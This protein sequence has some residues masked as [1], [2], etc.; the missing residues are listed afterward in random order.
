M[1]S[2]LLAPVGNFIALQAAIE[3]GADEIFFGVQGFNMRANA[4]NFKQSD[5]K[6]VIKICH[7]NDVKAY[8]AINIIIYENELTKLKKVL[9]K[10]KEAEID[11]II[12]WDM[13]VVSEAEKLKIPIHLSTQASVSNYESL[14]YYKN[15]IKL[16]ERVVLA[17]ECTLDQIK[18][19]IKKIKRDK[20]G[21]EIETFIH[22]AMCVSV[23][24]RCFMSQDMFGKSANRGE[25]IQ[26]C[27]REYDTIKIKDPEENKELYLG[28][29]YVMSPKDMCT[30]KIIDL[31]ID[32]GITSFK[33]E[34]RNRN[35]EYVANVI[36][37][38]RTIMDYYNEY[39]L[40]IKQ[41]PDDKKEYEKLKKQL[42]LKLDNSYNRGFSDGFYMGKPINQ[43][44]GVYGSKSKEHKQ[45]VG[46]ITNYFKKI[47]VAEI[48]VT[49][50]SIKK[51]DE[52]YIQGPTTGVIKQKVS[53][54][55]T[56]GIDNNNNKCNIIIKEATK[57]K[58]ISIKVEKLVRKNDEL[59]KII[60]KTK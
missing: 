11:A 2:K 32:A 25:C 18:S 34:G 49:S 50:Y 39:K 38:Y 44:S 45:Y 12:A 15:K 43:W 36:D 23:S 16:L 8:L 6:K 13:A 21:V 51:N 1:Y 58:L 59:Y 35:P 3:S 9:K 60:K 53:D 57:G 54:I 40:K 5:L 30:M 33:V 27:R 46:K 7:D 37:C 22:G 29:D 4:K 56:D 31:L 52:I 26:P 10:A 47:G 14:K 28:K 42:L 41:N 20:L 17:R 19:I 24:G 48:K 55:Y